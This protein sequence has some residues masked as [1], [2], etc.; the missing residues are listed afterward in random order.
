V[1]DAIARLGLSVGTPPQPIKF[2]SLSD[3]WQLDFWLADAD[4]VPQA[5]PAEPGAAP[6]PAT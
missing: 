3:E 4:P 1:C 2:L 5:S 6:D